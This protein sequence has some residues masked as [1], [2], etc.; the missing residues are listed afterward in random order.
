MDTV[1]IVMYLSVNPF[2]A[3]FTIKLAAFYHQLHVLKSHYQIVALRDIASVLRTKNGKPKLAIT[4]DDAF[5][6]FIEHAFPILSKLTLP[7]SIFVP[8]AFIGKYN[9]WDV[10][11]KDIPKKR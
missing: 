7:C 2:I 4:F 1:T 9:R 8:T 11:N 3:P 6:D 10:C 5:G